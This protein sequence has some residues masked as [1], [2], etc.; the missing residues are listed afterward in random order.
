MNVL[1]AVIPAQAGMIL[2]AIT[3]QLQVQGYPCTSGDDPWINIS[4]C[5]NTKLS[6]HKRG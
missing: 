2:Q 6:L 3:L 5:L 1:D 4:E